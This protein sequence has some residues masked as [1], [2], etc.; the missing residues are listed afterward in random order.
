MSKS[1]MQSDKTYCWSCGCS[2]QQRWIEEHHVFGASNRKK[3]EH[4]GL[5]VYLCYVCHRDNTHGI[6]GCNAELRKKLFEEGQ[7]AF[8]RVHGTREEFMKVFGRNYL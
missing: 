4:Y 3:S 2:S 5:K 6:H 7:Q 1:I 8:E